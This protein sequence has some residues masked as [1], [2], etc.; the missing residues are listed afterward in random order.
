MLTNII[1]IKHY[2]E[3]LQ[4]PTDCAKKKNPTKVSHDR[5]QFQSA[6]IIVWGNLS[7]TLS[8]GS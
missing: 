4:T 8:F 7:Q 6:F 1:F 5:L 3:N 2:K